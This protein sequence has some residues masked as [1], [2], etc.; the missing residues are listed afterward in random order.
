[1]SA[2]LKPG[3]DLLHRRPDLIAHLLRR[4]CEAQL[5]GWAERTSRAWLAQNG[6]E[7]ELPPRDPNYD[8]TILVKCLI[9]SSEP[10]GSPIGSVNV[11]VENADIGA[12]RLEMVDTLW[13]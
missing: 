4:D 1:V 11:F 6:A 3:V 2:K 7:F 13:V 8:R 9:S 10:P 12:V 5:V